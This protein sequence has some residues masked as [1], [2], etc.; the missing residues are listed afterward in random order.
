[1]I[2]F[3]VS[4]ASH[5]PESHPPTPAQPAQELA[6]EYFGA[7]TQPPEVAAKHAKEIGLSVHQRQTP[8][9]AFERAAEELVAP[10]NEENS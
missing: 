9:E 10:P 5:T 6:R 7:S 2:Y 4:M 8:N 3:I 1:M